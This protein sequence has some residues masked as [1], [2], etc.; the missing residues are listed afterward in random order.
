MNLHPESS[1]GGT[2]PE[3]E[4]SAQATG[5]ATVDF[6]LEVVILPVSDVDRAKQ[7]YA[8]LGWRLDADFPIRDDFRVLQFTPPGSTASVIFGAG[9]SPAAPGSGYGLLAVSD[10]EAARASLAARGVDV[11]EV[12][13]GASGFDLAGTDGR[14]TGPDPQ[15]A[16]YKS[17]AQFSDPDGNTWLVQELT[18]RLPGR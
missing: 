7:F 12:F 10:V 3:A 15:R 16:S 2:V 13:H 14:V 11:S 6:K 9:V 1:A 18:D 8:S 17:W 4:L 5:T